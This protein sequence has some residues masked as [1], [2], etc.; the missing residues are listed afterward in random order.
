MKKVFDH[1]LK[2]FTLAEVIVTLALT[3]MVIV[4]A[5]GILTY[6]QK[7]FYSYKG[8][9]RFIQEYTTFK[10]RM[11]HEALYSAYITEQSETTF[12][13]KRDSVIIDLEILSNVVLL[14]NGLVCDTFHFAALQLK[15]EYEKMP[16]TYSL[17]K[18]IKTLNFDVEFSKQ[19][20]S[21]MF[22]KDY[23]AS[24]KLKL[25]RGL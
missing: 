19:K 25:D 16:D 14:K 5:Y 9:N 13:I 12:K 10:E 2:G 6:V 18:L 15:K 3:S 17:N 1:T 11:D 7:L 8:Q 23:D 21:F 20:F 22:E 4:F 24:V